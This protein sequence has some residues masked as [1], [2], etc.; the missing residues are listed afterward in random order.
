[1]RKY[2]FTRPN[3]S[4]IIPKVMIFETHHSGTYVFLYASKDDVPSHNDF[5]FDDLKDAEDYCKQYFDISTND[6][7]QIEDPL[8]VCQHDLIRPIRMK[9]ILNDNKYE[10][11]IDNQW[12]DIEL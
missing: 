6:W 8:E 2:A 12:K 5:W 1:M 7:I 10:I 9:R 3:H 11:L 4:H